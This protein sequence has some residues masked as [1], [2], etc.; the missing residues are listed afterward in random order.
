MNMIGQ[1]LGHYHILEQL[2]EGGMATVYK[3]YDTHLERDVAIKVIRLDQFTPASLQSVLARFER[4]AKSLARL[5]HPNIVHI[6]DYGE[7]DNVP[8]LVMDYLPGGTLKGRLGQPMKW[9]DASRLLLPIAQALGYAHEQNLIHR[10]VKPSNILMTKKGQPML[11]DFGIAKILDTGGQTLTATGVGI[12]TP[13]YMAPEQW[14]GKTTPQSDIYSLGVVLYEML[15][16]R[17]PYTAD[18]PAAILIKQATEALPRPKQYIPDLPEAVEKVLIKAMA[19]EPADRYETMDDFARALEGLLADAMK[20][21]QALPT[22]AAVTAAKTLASAEGAKPVDLPTMT[23]EG[24]KEAELKTVLAP[25]PTGTGKP[26]PQVPVE[27][28]TGKSPQR[29]WLW[30]VAGVVILAA[31]GL[32]FLLLNPFGKGASTTN[33]KATIAPTLAVAINPA[34]PTRVQATTAPAFSPE[35]CSTPEVFCVGLVTDMGTVNDKGFNQAAWE[36]IL[37]AKEQGLVQVAQFI[38]TQDTK[39]YE[40]NIAV[41]A[42]GGYDMIVTAGWPMNQV[43]REAA[44]M[45]PD[46]L[47]IGLDQTLDPDQSW[48]ANF[49]GL[50]FPE[51]QAGFPGR[52]IGLPHEPERIYRGGVRYGRCPGGFAIWR[53]LSRR[54]GVC[55]PADRQKHARGCGLP[56]Q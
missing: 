43:T 15:T 24:Q 6:N 16:G 1:T 56:P 41:F 18:T 31:L 9:Q 52:R 55:R 51:D 45:Y 21:E 23:V 27:K 28:P 44:L 49:T 10:D 19:K 46:V 11:T 17:P 33:L 5:T 37:L 53:W 32:A 48:P 50:S 54:R 20:E 36:G 38:E 7:Q 35:K 47:F 25:L 4:E 8:Y 14:T 26:P 39:D 30:A 42:D 22:M 13:E 29:W 2:G 3:A 34:T 40:K 12:G